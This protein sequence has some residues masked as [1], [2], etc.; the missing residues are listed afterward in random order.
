MTDPCQTKQDF[1]SACN[2][3]EHYIDLAEG[4]RRAIGTLG[5]VPSTKIR[6]TDRFYVE[7]AEYD[8]WGS[9]DS[10]VLILELE[11]Q[12]GITI[13]DKIAQSIAD[14]ELTPGYT[15]A[16]FVQS[17]ADAVGDIWLAKTKPDHGST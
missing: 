16:A 2:V 1:A 12:L 11:K 15:V 10:V 9:L 14:P 17:I 4:V 7:L 8:F 6:S 5:N 3:Q 13:D